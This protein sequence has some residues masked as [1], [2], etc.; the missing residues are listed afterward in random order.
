MFEWIENLVKAT[1]C[2]WETAER[3]YYA[4]FFPDSY[5]PE[6]YEG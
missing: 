5:E 6:D 4:L 2:S 3:E 1:G